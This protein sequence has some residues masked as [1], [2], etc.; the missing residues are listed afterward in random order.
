MAFFE[1]DGS[2]SS[3]DPLNDSISSSLT[4]RITRS[5]QSQRHIALGSSSS[6]RK[7]TFE[8]EVGD[9]RSPQRLFVT[10]E[11]GQKESGAVRRRLFA[12]PSPSKTPASQRRSRTTTTTIPLRDVDSTDDDGGAEMGSATPKRRG[13]PRKY[14]PTPKPG[15]STKKR[16]ASP[17]RKGTPGRPRKARAVLPDEPPS[18]ASTQ[19]TPRAARTRRTTASASKEPASDA[20]V[21]A[22]PASS[23]KR[24]SKR[25]AVSDGS[26]SIAPS[27]TKKRGR[28]RKNPLPIEEEPEL[29]DEQIFAPDSFAAENNSPGVQPTA[30]QSDSTRATSPI[31]SMDDAVPASEGDIWMETLSDQ[32]TPRPTAPRIGSFQFS[33]SVIRGPSARQSPEAP[34][35]SNEANTEMNDYALAAETRDDTSSVSSRGTTEQAGSDIDDMMMVT[36]PDTN[37]ASEAMSEANYS[38]AGR[39]P[40]ETDTIVQSEEF[41]MIFTNSLSSIH[42]IHADAS[43]MAIASDEIGEE[44]NLFIN[45]TLETIKNGMQSESGSTG[46]QSPGPQPM[47]EEDQEA[48]EEQREQRS[49][50]ALVFS[51]EEIDADFG[52]VEDEDV[53]ESESGQ[54]VQQSSPIAFSREEL[55]A[56]LGDV[57]E[58]EG[59]DEDVEE[60]PE[61]SR[62]YS[63]EL[64]AAQFDMRAS[65]HQQPPTEDQPERSPAQSDASP[66]WAGSPRR[67]KPLP[68]SRQ[69]LTFKAMQR[70]QSLAGDSPS[71]ARFSPSRPSSRRS[72][73][74][75]A[76]ESNLYEDSFSA[77]PEEILEAATPHRPQRVEMPLSNQ[78]PFIAPQPEEQVK[79]V[80]P[81]SGALDTIRSDASRLLTP[82]ETPSPRSSDGD[83]DL[84]PAEQSVVASAGASV[85]SQLASSPTNAIRSQQQFLSARP[86]VQG[87]VT[88]TGPNSSPHLPA[89]P[90][91]NAR[92]VP[93]PEQERRPALSPIVR[94]GL[95]LQSV[96]SDHSSPVGPRNAL[97]SPF[98][99]S[100]NPTPRLG[101]AQPSHRT[102]QTP[103]APPSAYQSEMPPSN[104]DPFGPSRISHGQAS[105]LRAL[106]ESARQL[107][108]RR[109]SQPASNF[110]TTRATFDDVDEMS[111]IAEDTVPAPMA[112][113]TAAASRSSSMGANFGS[114]AARNNAA[115]VEETGDASEEEE[116]IWVAEAQRP[117]PNQPRQQSFGAGPAQRQA[118]RTLIPDTWRRN[119]RTALAAKV[120]TPA[121]GDQ[122]QLEE[123][124]LLS[125]QNKEA[126][127]VQASSAAK[128]G[129]TGGVDLSKFFS[130]PA[131]LP[132]LPVAGNHT[133]RSVAAPAPAPAPALPSNSMFPPV[134]QKDFQP[135]P[136]RRNRLFSSGPSTSAAT[137]VAEPRAAPSTSLGTSVAEQQPPA[138]S[139]PERIE[140]PVVEQKKNFTPRRGQGNQS[141]FAPPSSAR[142]AVVP[143]P[144]QMQLS[145]DDIERWQVETSASL[146]QSPDAPRSE[147]A[148]VVSRPTHRIMSPTKSCLRS[149]LKP[150]TPGR[151]VEFASSTMSPL[152]QA[153]ARAASSQGKGSAPRIQLKPTAQAKP[154]VQARPPVQLKP[155][156]Q[157]GPTIQL[158]P[159]SQPTPMVQPRSSV[160][161]KP[162]PQ[163]AQARFASQGRSIA[164]T[165][166]LK[167]ATRAPVMFYDE[168]KE[169]SPSEVS[170]SEASSPPKKAA[171]RAQ[172]QQQRIPEQLSQKIWSKDH[173][174][175]LDMLLQL[176]RRGP[177]PF[178]LEAEGYVTG[179]KDLL[180]TVATT[181][182]RESMRLEAW[183]LD[184]VDAFRAE[185]GGWEERVLAKRL[186]SLIAGEEARGLGR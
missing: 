25:K 29:P 34:P 66:R 93:A 139:T 74:N 138:P 76:D 158:K 146:E 39:K 4:R 27:S 134:P 5:H 48:E 59:P 83:A 169:N 144:P 44:T 183:H 77:V 65:Q 81:V 49:S 22:T 135:S 63:P 86:S 6:P 147:R 98:K 7:Q 156:V 173:W 90:D 161:P 179:S 13:R 101:S 79:E 162:A 2:I 62:N 82:D 122:S 64:P 96:T 1:D 23:V 166:Q 26:S 80:V 114:L 9:N 56:D 113:N 97:R 37:A 57:E 152:Q 67:I 112:T 87:K 84:K 163:Q 42:P 70:E 43:A 46:E 15:T 21:Q 153:Q 186:F 121:R 24:G 16:A 55:E 88:P 95:A 60:L 175:L 91:A 31:A 18:E 52:H 45:K 124:S 54:P 110:D 50:P 141:L 61:H 104:D 177:F 154:T 99:A 108:T 75:P 17:V 132:P 30:F 47:Y 20:T 123:Y 131:V 103:A 71:Q 51:Q 120:A 151:V 11:S 150:R 14:A 85:H 155:T 10:V 133:E 180:G 145:R 58:E 35:A 36:R 174:H 40:R 149:P 115:E 32:A 128:P 41:S 127:V 72:S 159:T 8:L 178:D 129:F 105:F 176:R 170:M 12:S 148:P 94:A 117:T 102:E 89:L 130:S 68:L 73:V 118:R 3:P 181:G 125:Q 160:Q 143:T 167:P 100:G 33:S 168:D 171:A 119:G 107:E 53:E 78:S 142:S 106:D 184:I 19:A 182:G 136:A 111:W 69:L 116:D 137:S 164:P 140:L 185:V 126:S 38:E 109:A 157:L 28:P 165:V 172:Q 92:T